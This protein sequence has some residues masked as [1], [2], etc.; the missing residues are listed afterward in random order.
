MC[1]RWVKRVVWVGEARSGVYEMSSMHCLRAVARQL[2]LLPL[3][4]GLHVFRERE[5]DGY[6]A[7][8]LGY[9]IYPHN[10]AHP[11]VLG[12]TEHLRGSV[13]ATGSQ[14][15]TY[16]HDPF[17]RGVSLGTHTAGLDSPEHP[18]GP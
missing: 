15:G 18:D 8:D 12:D 1:A 16:T 11:G 4:P 10:L 3:R 2:V 9:R 6:H 14:R 5:V 13:P 7:R 17:L